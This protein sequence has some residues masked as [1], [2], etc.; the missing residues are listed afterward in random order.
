MPNWGL[1]DNL[2]AGCC[3]EVPCLVDGNAIQPTRVGTLPPQLAALNRTNIDVQELIVEAALTGDVEA[4][5]HAVML[6]PLTAAVCS[7]PQ[8]RAMV[9]EVSLAEARCLPQF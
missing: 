3:V 9:D 6:D 8:I 2:P 4:T 1:I 5:Y 7:L